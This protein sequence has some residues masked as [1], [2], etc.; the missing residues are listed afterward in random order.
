MIEGLIHYWSFK[1]GLNDLV[2]GTPLKLE[3]DS[4]L[5]VDRYGQSNSAF[6]T[7]QGFA[8]LPPGVYLGQQ[9]TICFWLKTVEWDRPF[10]IFDFSDGY[11]DRILLKIH[12]HHLL[13]YVKNTGQEQ[14]FQIETDLRDNK[15]HHI[16]LTFAENKIRSYVDGVLNNEGHMIMHSTV[17]KPLNYFGRRHFD[18]HTNTKI[19]L[20]DI[21]I[22]GQA[23]KSEEVSY[24]SRA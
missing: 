14:R 7:N 5:D 10:Y 12:T 23:L 16:T 3:G 8:W 18:Y 13:Y 20:A 17:V 6:K 11:P 9:F 21:M 19:K 15:W 22:F 24:I 2:S 4:G 1:Y